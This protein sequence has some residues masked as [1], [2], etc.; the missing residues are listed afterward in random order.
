[1]DDVSLAEM[2]VVVLSSVVLADTPQHTKCVGVKQGLFK[3][4]EFL[5]LVTHNDRTKLMTHE[6][7]TDRKTEHHLVYKV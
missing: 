4:L 7:T 2:C 1:V 3:Y 6:R 5:R